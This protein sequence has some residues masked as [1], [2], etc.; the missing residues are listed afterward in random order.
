[1]TILFRKHVPT[2]REKLYKVCHVA[3]A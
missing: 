3:S 1:M 2:A